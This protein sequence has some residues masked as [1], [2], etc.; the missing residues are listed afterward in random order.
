MFPGYPFMIKAC[1]CETVTRIKRLFLPLP[2]Q[3]VL[4]YHHNLLHRSSG[5]HCC[6]SSYY[7]SYMLLQLHLIVFSSSPACFLRHRRPD[8]PSLV[9]YFSIR[10]CRKQRKSRIPLLYPSSWN[11]YIKTEF[12]H[13]I[14]ILQKLS[15][16]NTK[17]ADTTTEMQPDRRYITTCA[18]TGNMVKLRI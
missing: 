12:L 8:T 5:K 2:C 6:Q 7:L 15:K 11:R 9:V 13:A 10:N 1:F 18:D 17:T 16:R 3:T 14:V 4:L